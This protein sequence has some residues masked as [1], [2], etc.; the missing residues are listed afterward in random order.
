[1]D[2][3]KSILVSQ[4]KPEGE[5]S[6]YFDLAE[7]H[8]LKID[9]RPFI[10]VQGVDVKD[11]RAQ[12]VNI[13]EH[14]AVIFTSKNSADHFFRICEEARITVPESMKYFCVTE[15]IAFYLQNYVVYRKRKIFAGKTDF[16]SLVEVIRKHKSEYYYLPCSDQMKADVTALLDKYNIRYTR[17]EIYRTVSSDLSDL[18]DV[19]YDVLAFFS[20][21]GIRSLFEN[22][23]DFEQN[24]TRIAAFGA[25]TIK[26]VEDRGLMVNIPAPVPN[27]PSKTMALDQ[28]VT[29]ANKKTK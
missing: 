21:W 13:L 19:N 2:K 3:V 18:A 1:M 20:P 26:A 25:A 4:P 22:F 24:K 12:R 5:K 17:S 10:Q 29:L 27:A 6:P 14:S 28:Y 8:N 23:P 16:A 11:F 15:A 9:F 7:K